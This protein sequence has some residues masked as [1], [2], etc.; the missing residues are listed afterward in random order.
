MP[1]IIVE[2]SSN[3]SMP[4]SAQAV[5]QKLHETLVATHDSFRMTD[6]KSRIVTHDDYR[7]SDG[8]REQGFIHVQLAILP[9][10]PE[11][12]KAA[13]QNLHASVSEIFASSLA[14]KNYSITAEIRDMCKDTYV[15]GAGGNL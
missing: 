1:H 4:D 8:E 13:A 2:K 7:V 6:I 10:D 14:G 15:K 11:V 12:R 3:I 9:R 5:L